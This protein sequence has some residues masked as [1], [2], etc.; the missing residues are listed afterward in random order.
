MIIQNTYTDTISID[1]SEV[2]GRII[3]ISAKDADRI[4]TP[5]VTLSVTEDDYPMFRDVAD[6]VSVQLISRLSDVL[7]EHGITTDWPLFDVELK[8]EAIT[9]KG[10]HI[11][12]KGINDAFTY[13]VLADMQMGLMGYEQLMMANTIRYED[14]LKM[15]ATASTYRRGSKISIKPRML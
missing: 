11:I 7:G 1:L 6:K 5:V 9:L 10:L 14:A 8:K 13:G 2:F 4:Q 3:N 12:D 15:V